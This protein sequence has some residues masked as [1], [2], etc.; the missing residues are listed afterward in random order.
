[1]YAGVKYRPKPTYL[2]NACDFL[3]AI[4]EIYSKDASPFNLNIIIYF[5][6]IVDTFRTSHL[7]TRYVQM[8]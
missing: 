4:E 1:M 7:T 8:G 2:T 5:V 6:L 3:N